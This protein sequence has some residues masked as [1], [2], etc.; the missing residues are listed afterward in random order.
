MSWG[1]VVVLYSELSVEIPELRVVELLPIIDMRDL[2]I[3][4]L[5]IIERQTKLHTLCSVIVAKGSV[6]AHLVK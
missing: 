6:S 5:H 1:R 2:E 3:P 4:N